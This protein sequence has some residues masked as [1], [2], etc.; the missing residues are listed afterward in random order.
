MHAVTFYNC[1][2]G[3]KAQQERRS[4]GSYHGE[5]GTS[6]SRGSQDSTEHTGTVSYQ[7][8]RPG[9]AVHLHPV[10]VHVSHPDAC[11]DICGR[12]F[13]LHCRLQTILPLQIRR[14][15]HDHVSHLRNLCVL[16]L[17]Y[18]FRWTVIWVSAIMIINP[19]RHI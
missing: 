2:R 19:K 5:R 8:R 4:D 15:R 7:Y 18:G 10:G 3:W 17:L 13:R 1:R 9:G 6:C 14:G 16:Y 11:V 12:S